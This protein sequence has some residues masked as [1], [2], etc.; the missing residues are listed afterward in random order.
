MSTSEQ[1]P[2]NVPTDLELAYR[3][4]IHQAGQLIDTLERLA[5]WLEA[6]G[7]GSDVAVLSTLAEHEHRIAA[8]EASNRG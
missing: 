3:E 7:V 8:L 5:T 4:R 2:R 1:E 6:N